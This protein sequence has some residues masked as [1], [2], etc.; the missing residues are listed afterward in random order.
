[1]KRFA[2]ALFLLTAVV[3]LYRKTVRLWWTYDD[4]WLL[5]L[6]IER[7]WTQAFLQSET[8][9]RASAPLLDSTYEVMVALADLHAHRWYRLLLVVLALSAVALFATLRLYLKTLPALTGA[10]LFVAGAPACTF[11]TQLMLIHY[12]EAILLGSL[13]VIAFVYASRRQ[14]NTLNVLSA[15]LYIGSMLAERFTV[16]LPLLLLVLPEREMRVRARH[17][18]VHVFAFVAYSVWRSST[19]G[20]IFGDVGWTLS[21]GEVP[22]LVA[23]LPWKIVKEW[24]GASIG[25][26]MF[27]VVLVALG[28]VLA[29]WTRRAIVIALTAL[30]IVLAPIVLPSKDMQPRWAFIPWLW[31]C[32]VFA[33]GVAT[34]RSAPQKA[35][36]VAAAAA[37]VIA[38]RQEWTRQFARSERMSDE[39]RAFI[40][41]QSADVLRLPAVPPGAMSELRWLKED[42]LQRVRGSGWY[43]DDLYLCGAALQEKRFYEYIP[44]R[45][46]VVEVTARIPDYASGYCS[47]I[48]ETAPLRAEFRHRRDAL[49]WRFGPYEEGQYRVVLAGGLQA[50]DVPREDG[51]KLPGVP[52]L[53]L[54]VKYQSPE[55]W[56]TYSPEIHL[57]FARQPEL[58]WHR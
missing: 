54:R 47:S 29:L 53:S 32:S 15:L 17:L 16:P 30:L 34:L 51:F 22:R 52:G 3:L 19:G 18:I 48:R 6:A 5:H 46:E 11:V 58:E 40:N 37:M 28:M 4:P 1:M 14:S 8:W 56:V 41:L 23:T 42:H 33:C 44:E 55:G 10:F 26:G 50:F 43:Y 25:V 31:A 13:S 35:L 49:F 20:G 24:A 12:L 21:A 45:R 38:N 7:P 39:A 36:A 2:A 57:E 27:A 9:H